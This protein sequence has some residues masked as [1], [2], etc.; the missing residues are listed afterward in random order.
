MAD[1]LEDSAQWRDGVETRLGRLEVTVEEQARLRAAMDDLSRLHVERDL[2]QALHDTQQEHTAQL[3][4]HTARLARLETGLERVHVGV[5][6]I[7]E[8]LDRNL[9]STH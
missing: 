4:D 1:D 6:T 9:S 2:L 7:R 8:I 5:E 3:R